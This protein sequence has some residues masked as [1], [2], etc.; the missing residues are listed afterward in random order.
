M[1]INLLQ[2]KNDL[3]PALLLGGVA[4]LPCEVS[5]SAAIVSRINSML[6]ETLERLPHP[7]T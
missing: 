6:A 3:P 2:F 1:K 7:A 4:G 5:F